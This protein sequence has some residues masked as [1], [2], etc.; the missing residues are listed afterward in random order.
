MKFFTRRAFTIIETLVVIGVMGVMIGLLMSAV[1]SARGAAYRAA[2]ANNLKQ[3]ALASH[4]YHD[5]RGAFPAALEGFKDPGTLKFP[6]TNWCISLLPHLEQQALW[7]QTDV[8]MS[9]PGS[10]NQ[11]PPH[12][13]MTTIVKVF[14]CPADGR[15]SSVIT[16]DRNYT[17]AY[18]SYEGIA[19]SG[20]LPL[21]QGYDGVMRVPN[22]V[23]IAEI[24]DG[25]SSTLVFGEKP[26]WGRY[27]GGTWY[28]SVIDD[29]HLTEDPDWVGGS[30][31]S[32]NVFSD[33]VMNNG[34]RGP[35]KL[36]P[37]R[38]GNRCDALHFWSLH[39]GGANFA[40]ADGSVQFLNYSADSVMPA[41][42]TRAGGEPDHLD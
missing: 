4:L 19:G 27:F 31:A 22:G 30:I 29:P 14:A 1:Q 41:L 8:A 2:C 20:L 17:A 37:G 33:G 28:A 34:C 15:L 38:L 39:G 13:G 6:L 21:G 10:Q 24:T 40:F 18:G 12:V 16:D 35:F 42:A 5:S 11:N 25:T 3:I 7:Q 26:P 36:G 23:R 32:M 9:F